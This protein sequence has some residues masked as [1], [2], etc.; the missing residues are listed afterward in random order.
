MNLGQS[1]NARDES[2]GASADLTP[3]MERKSEL[4]VVPS[5]DTKYV[6][7]GISIPED[8]PADTFLAYLKADPLTLSMAM[9]MLELSWNA[10][11]TCM[12][13]FLD[14]KF[15]TKPSVTAN[16]SHSF[17]VVI[18]TF[19]I[20]P[21]FDL[22]KT[23]KN[24]FIQTKP[25]TDKGPKAEL[26]QEQNFIA[27]KLKKWFWEEKSDLL[28]AFSSCYFISKPIHSMTA[29]ICSECL[30]LSNG[31]SLIVGA[32]STTATWWAGF[33]YLK[34]KRDNIVYKMKHDPRRVWMFKDIDL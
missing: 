14:S 19:L 1:N 10:I 29:H 27:N 15:D 4:Q 7:T 9:I 32:L 22:S 13:L 16:M 20:T 33:L 23:L 17:S 5:R 28:L 21:A 3:K 8:K 11:V 31:L 6:E 30:G 2:K 18:H 24:Y 25:S 26:A 34:Y 12:S